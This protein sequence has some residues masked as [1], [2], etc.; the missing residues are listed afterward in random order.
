MQQQFFG[1]KR[2]K[3]Q[4]ASFSFLV[5]NSCK[6][7]FGRKN[8]F[9][10]RKIWSLYTLNC[11][12][13]WHLAEGGTSSIRL[14]VR[15]YK[16]PGES[17]LSFSNNLLSGSAR[18]RWAN[19]FLPRILKHPQN[20]EFRYLRINSWQN[21]LDPPFDHFSHIRSPNSPEWGLIIILG[22]K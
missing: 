14:S 11:P 4:S 21:Q 17:S 3:P 9:S 1:K 10:L 7:F 19:V 18:V 12:R 6:F 16:E 13:R 15:S 20:R 8:S 22:M 2:K 5:K